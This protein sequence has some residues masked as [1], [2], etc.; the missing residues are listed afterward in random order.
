MILL[1]I[2]LFLVGVISRGIISVLWEEGVRRG[3][4]GVVMVR[5][6]GVVELC[7]G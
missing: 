2:D 5:F 3:W 4:F 7:R 6:L 1:G